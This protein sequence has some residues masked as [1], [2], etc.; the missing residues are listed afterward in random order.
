MKTAVHVAA[1]SRGECRGVAELPRRQTPRAPVAA[2]TS[3]RTKPSVLTLAELPAS[4]T[5][6]VWPMLEED[7]GIAHVAL[8]I[9]ERGRGRQRV[10]GHGRQVQAVDGD[11]RR[12]V[13]AGGELGVGRHVDDLVSAQHG[14]AQLLPAAR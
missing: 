1:D 4:S 3:I 7:E 13:A 5:L 9:G 14:E 2:S 12:A 6:S 11:L 8:R 10:V